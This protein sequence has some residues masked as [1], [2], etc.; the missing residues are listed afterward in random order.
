MI[1]GVNPTGADW[2]ART[3][4][5]VNGDA[6][7]QRKREEIL[8]SCNLRE[9]M[10]IPRVY[11][12]TFHETE[13]EKMLATASDPGGR[14]LSHWITNKKDVGYSRVRKTL[15]RAGCSFNL[16]E[17]LSKVSYVTHLMSENPVSMAG[18][19]ICKRFFTLCMKAKRSTFHK[20]YLAV[21][22]VVKVRTRTLS[23]NRKY[24]W[25]TPL[26]SKREKS[27][28]VK[29]QV[30]VPKVYFRLIPAKLE[31]DTKRYLNWAKPKLVTP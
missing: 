26:V 2:N 27:F 8:T 23:P 6:L 12:E 30:Y 14:V 1:I 31:R 16:Q 4:S 21:L 5:I 19:R 10:H 17:R 11:V 24:S 20:V 28:N 3:F 13:G 25:H 29:L 7:P 15:P 9:L 22:R 18:I